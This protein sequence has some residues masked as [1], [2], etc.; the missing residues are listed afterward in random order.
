M[1]NLQPHYLPHLTS[2]PPQTPG[3]QPTIQRWK[4]YKTTGILT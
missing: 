4:L 3:D 2:F 1:S